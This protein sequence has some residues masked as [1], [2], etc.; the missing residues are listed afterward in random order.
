MKKLNY[1]GIGILL[2]AANIATGQTGTIEFADPIV[3]VVEVAN[4]LHASTPLT[5]TVRRLGGSSGPAQASYAV[6]DSSITGNAI[7][8]TNYSLAGNIRKWIAAGRVSWADGDS[9]DKT[10]IIKSEPSV[11]IRFSDQVTGTLRY[12]ARLVNVTGATLGTQSTARFEVLDAQAPAAGVLRFSSRVF[13]G[14]EGGTA[15]ISVRRDGGTSGSVAV[16]YAT[17]SSLP[18]LSSFSQVIPAGVV[19]VNYLSASG[20]LTWSDGDAA[21]KSF[22][23]MLPATG[24]TAG[25]MQVALNL[26]SPSGGAVLGT[27]P[28]ALLAIQNP[29]SNQFDFN[30]RSFASW[31]V[32]VPSGPEP[33]R[34][35]LFSFPG[36]FGD[37]R[38]IPLATMFQNAARYWRFALVGVGSAT[39][40]D[41]QFNDIAEIPL[42]GW[43][44]V[45]DL[46]AGTSGRPELRNAPFAFRGMSAGGYSSSRSFL[47][48]PER[49]IGAMCHAGWNPPPSEAYNPLTP[50]QSQ[51]PAIALIGS[52]DATV[53]ISEIGPS[54][55]MSRRYGQ[56]RLALA[57]VWGLS[58]NFQNSSAYNAYALYWFDQ[59]MKAGRYPAHLVPTAST[60]PVLGQLPMN[61]GWWG[62]R[63]S[64]NSSANGYQLSGGS[65]RFLNIGPDASFAG[66]K[67]PS[68]PLVDSW[69][70]NQSAAMGYRSLSSRASIT[71]TSPGTFSTVS[72]GAVT[73]ITTSLSTFASVITQMEFF[74]GDTSIGIDTSEPYSMPWVPS[75]TGMRNLTVV[76]SVTSGEPLTVSRVCFVAFANVPASPTGVAASSAGTGIL[77]EWTGAP[78][79]ESYQIWRA[80]A[81]AGPFSLLRA[82][83][84]N[85]SFTDV[86]VIDGVTYFYQVRGVNTLGEGALSGV[87]SATA[88]GAQ[89]DLALFRQQYGIEADG[90]EDL[91]IPASD[92]V[93]NILKYAFN[94]MGSG[95]AQQLAL[96]SPNTA[97]MNADGQAGLPRIEQ[98]GDMPTRLI[99]VRRKA[100]SNPEIIYQVEHSTDLSPGSWQVNA[101]ITETVNSLTTALERVTIELP[102]LPTASFCRLKIIIPANP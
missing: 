56:T 40:P 53:P 94:M 95:V 3:T 43:F 99:F 97:V 51:V 89:S 96:D 88:G 79:S 11:G 44:D 33:I 90:S 98:T 10:I 19:G 63:N 27:L 93:A 36:S 17:S 84:P 32:W 55:S 2:A 9:S 29:R 4:Q 49:T 48:W 16:N 50:L 91:G 62:V 14:K 22:T 23:V 5:M 75:A 20:T 80:T 81:A 37:T 60:A 74:D 1:T 21:E 65:S 24:S 18:T 45:V 66:I 54:M 70:P 35:I 69:L 52:S 68:N 46:V 71:I 59:L 8:N 85:S 25:Q 82:G 72:L 38:D 64:T 87:V 100:S 47:P 61:S 76:A 6:W 26:T 39:T 12:D 28:S 57:T 77:L 30:D 67:D 92:G 42:G 41:P 102:A 13:F 78:F 58:H 7:E 31:R 34:G 15:Q 73:N 83:H 101:A 86:E